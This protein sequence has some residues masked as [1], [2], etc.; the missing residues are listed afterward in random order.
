MP[1]AKIKTNSAILLYFFKNKA[2]IKYGEYEPYVIV[3]GKTPHSKTSKTKHNKTD[4]HMEAWN[5][6]M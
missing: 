5:S 6:E 2:S 4:T 3:T 1:K